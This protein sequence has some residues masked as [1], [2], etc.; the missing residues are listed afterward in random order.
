M[1]VQNFLKFLM[2]NILSWLFAGLCLSRVISSI[3]VV[4]VC[5]IRRLLICIVR[6]L[7][8]ISII[9]LL[10]QWTEFIFLHYILLFLLLFLFCLFLFNEFFNVS[11]VER[12]RIVTFPL[13]IDKLLHIVHCPVAMRLAILL[14]RYFKVPL[15]DISVPNLL[16]FFVN[17]I[18]LSKFHVGHDV[19]I[20]E[21]QI[22]EK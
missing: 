14:K 9:I 19:V 1:S 4:C 17:F 16:D 12:L 10:G 3:I 7:I 15:I 11:L 13:I 5:I 6:L 20:L 21:L 2:S 22:V 8:S 18:F